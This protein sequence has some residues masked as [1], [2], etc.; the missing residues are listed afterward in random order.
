MSSID[1]TTPDSR[2][3]LSPEEALELHPKRSRPI[4]LNFKAVAVAIGGV[5][6]LVI[7]II[8]IGVAI[9]SGDDSQTTASIRSP[10]HLSDES[11]EQQGAVA[12][13]P[14]D[15]S[16]LR[17]IPPAEE[18]PLEQDVPE[19]PVTQTTQP[20]VQTP[21]APPT[22]DRQAELIE[23]MLTRMQAGFDS[24]VVFP[25][26]QQTQLQYELPN[27]D[28]DSFSRA[29][30]NSLITANTLQAPQSSEL[31]FLRNP[32]RL[33]HRVSGTLQSPFTPYE[34]RAGSVIPAALITA[35]H[36]DLPGDLIAQVSDNVYDAETGRHLL[37]PQGSRLLGTYS[38]DIPE[39][40]NRVLVVWQR[41]ILP[42]G[43]SISLDA[44]PGV[45]QTGAAGLHDQVD[46][47]IDNVV[48]AT[49]LSSA[50]AFTGNLARSRSEDGEA[51]SVVGETVAQE[52]ARFGQQIIDRELRRPPTI[53]VRSGWQFNVL[54]NK[55]IPLE[56]Y[57][58][59]RTR[60]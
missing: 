31:L 7:V 3:K 57:E 58:P 6:V 40:R 15:Y 23:E 60:R 4:K 18:E 12:Q 32:G 35:I 9:S 48:G 28:V 43:K 2:G 37:I 14:H 33:P 53:M 10:N 52:S 17:P 46:Y 41:L 36:S 29:E 34:L 49:A 20:R 24:P 59:V 25:R 30:L 8:L 45:D 13:L 38:S 50:I 51:L 47:H 39:G 19:R 42:N 55:D 44:M 1:V 16:F 26:S 5:G 27:R 11:I 21:E 54:V 22:E 56:V